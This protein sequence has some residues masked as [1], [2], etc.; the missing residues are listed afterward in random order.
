MLGPF[1]AD[2]SLG[3]PTS[4]AIIVAAAGIGSALGDLVSLRVEP[5]KP[6]RA[7]FLSMLLAPPLLIALAD[8]SSVWIIA[9]AALPWGVSMTFFNA[10][11]YTVLQAHVPERSISR[12]ASYDWLGSTALRPIGFALVG[13]LAERFGATETLLTIALSITAIEVATAFIPSVASLPRE[14]AAAPGDEE[15][16]RAQ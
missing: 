9:I 12:V 5:A 3:G 7:A 10:L 11:W 4:W 6:L 13:P 8:A 1:I 14:P 15:L 2:R 16:L